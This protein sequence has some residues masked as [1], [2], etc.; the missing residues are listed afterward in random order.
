M[1]TD[2]RVAELAETFRL[3]GDPSRLKIM[4]ACLDAPICV[5]DIASRAGLSV[6]LASHHLRLLRGARILRAERQGKRVFYA[7]Q[8]AH[9][10]CVL[11]DMVAHVAEAE[12][13]ADAA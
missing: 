12:E 10:A 2:D 8:D 6:S 9:V 5:G 4:L 7:A 11:Q 13:Q 3:M 1:L